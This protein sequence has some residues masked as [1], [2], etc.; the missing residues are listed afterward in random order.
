M[1][2]SCLYVDDDPALRE[3]VRLNLSLEGVTVHLAESGFGV[4]AKAMELSPDLILLDI[5]MPGRDGYDVLSGLRASAAT[6]DIPVIMISAR[7]SDS[8]I[9][10]GWKRGA[11]YYVTK[12]FDAEKLVRYL[13]RVHR[14]TQQARQAQPQAVPP[15]R[16]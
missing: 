2:L 4:E 3:L 14:E 11:D 13:R 8:D 15:R 7:A 6:R 1:P 16:V 5:M 12:P 9:W 10:E